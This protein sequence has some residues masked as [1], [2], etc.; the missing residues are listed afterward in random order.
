M[1]QVKN[2]DLSI[3]PKVA[4]IELRDFYSFLKSKY[5]ISNTKEE[6]DSKE[7][8]ASE[9]LIDPLLSLIESNKTRHFYVDPSIDLSAMANEVGDMEF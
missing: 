8:D 4:Q 5:A 7:K 1:K 9:D 2:L 3:L 6:C